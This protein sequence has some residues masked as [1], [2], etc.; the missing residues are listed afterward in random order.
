MRLSTGLGASLLA[1][2]G[3]F[4]GLALYL[5]AVSLADAQTHEIGST[6]AR[7]RAA[8]DPPQFGSPDLFDGSTGSIGTVGL[9]RR[10]DPL[11]LSD[12]QRGQI[13]LGVMNLPDI[14]DADISPRI[15]TG[16]LPASVELH[17]LPA[18]VTESVPKVKG[19]KFAKIWDRILVVDPATRNVVADI[20]RYHL[21]R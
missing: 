9:A 1:L 12:E 20:P 21:V 8:G 3:A 4:A 2:A 10:R 17:D 5:G 7:A 13:F 11:G 19:Y 14:S 15:T 6:S 18:M 16:W